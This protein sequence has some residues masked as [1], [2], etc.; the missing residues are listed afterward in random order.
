MSDA[1]SDQAVERT[2]V[3]TFIEKSYRERLLGMIGKPRARPKLRRELLDAARFDTRFIV[4][5][6]PYVHT[7]A[8]ILDLLRQRGAPPECYMVSERGRWDG[9][10]LSLPEALGLVIGSGWRTLVACRPESLV[11]Y[12]GEALKARIVLATSV[13]SDGGRTGGRTAGRTGP[14]GQGPLR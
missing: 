12:E 13:P 2:L 9:S 6:P 3:A 4:P 11:Y 7:D 1:E 14:A 8:A 5:I 10:R